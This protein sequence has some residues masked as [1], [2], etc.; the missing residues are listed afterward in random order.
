MMSKNFIVC[1]VGIILGF[2]LGFFIANAVSHPGG[3]IS[4]QRPDSIAG[5][6][7]LDENQSAGQLPPGHPNV[8]AQE[9][10]SETG[11]GAASTSAEAQAAMDK[12]DRSTQ[13]F[14]AQ[15]NAANIFYTL[16]DFQKSALYFERALKLQPQNFEALAGMGNTKYDTR[17]YVGAASFY[18]RALAV[19]PGEPDVR[20]DFGNTFFN[21]VPHDYE[22]AI[23]EYRKS[24]V[25]DPTHLNSWKNLATAALLL[26]DKPTAIEALT[27]LTELD[28]R[29]P[30][31]PPLRENIEALP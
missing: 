7:P 19:N 29:N 17:D 30:D 3:N 11:A 31:L 22:R 25:I 15:L 28:P 6:G 1:S 12:A 26:K 14:A 5:A 18:E 9:E 8:G 20:T 27:R 10:T 13:D 21:R 2:V 4:S 16:H 24:I 23:T